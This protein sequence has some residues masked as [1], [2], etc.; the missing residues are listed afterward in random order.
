MP[1]ELWAEKGDKISA[2]SPLHN[3][4]FIRARNINLN[5]EGNFPMFLLKK[6]TIFEKFS[7]FDNIKESDI[8]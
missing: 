1:E 8:H 7:A 5:R 4:G 6:Y 3:D 2:L